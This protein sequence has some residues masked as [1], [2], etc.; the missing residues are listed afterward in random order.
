MGFLTPAFL[1]GLAALGVPI[2][3][4]MTHRPRSETVAFPS[5]MFLQRIPY[6]SSRR[7]SLRHWLL[8]ALRAAAFVLLAFAFARPFFGTDRPAAAAATG[9]TTRIVLLDRSGS[10]GYADR[11]PKAVEAARRA[12]GEL[13]PEDRASLV[14]FDA[15]PASTGEPTADRARLSS[16]LG[17]ARAG[18]GGTRYAPALR[19]AAEMLE[20]ST[21]PRREVVL[22][23][24]FQKTGW[25]GTTDARLPADT[26]LQWVDV[27]GGGASNL[28]LTGVE[29]K[30]DYDAGRER[31]IASARIVNKSARPEKDLAL[32]LEVDGRPVRQARTSLGPNT[33]AMVAFEAFPLPDAAA[34]AVIRVAPRGLPADD[35]FHFVL[36]PG[37]DVPVLVL[38]GAGASDRRSLYLRRALAI[39][40][41]PR[42]RLDVKPAARVG[43]GD[44]AGA[45]LIVSNDAPPPPGAGGQ[46]LR[47]AVEK[48]A[49]LLIVAGDESAAR[50]WT[51]GAPSL[52][53][54][55][56]GR[57]TDRSWDRGG[58]LAYLDYDHPV[59][60][61]FRGPRGGDFSAARFVRYHSLDAKEGV[62]ARYDDGAIALAERKLGRGRVLVWTSSLDT[63]GNDLALQ[64]VF[65][66]FLHQLVKY[67][68]RHVDVRP[69]YTVGEVLDLSAEAELAGK[70]A[71]VTGPGGE[72]ERLPAGRPALEL[73]EPGFYEVRR[74]EGGSW[75]RLLAVNLDPAESDLFP[76]DPEELAGAVRPAEGVRAVRR[77]EPAPTREEHEDRQAFWR[78]LLLLALGLLAVETV[79]SNRPTAPRRSALGARP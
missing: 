12:L 28:A 57:A 52:L 49:G 21:S 20:G 72:T 79:L 32:V 73:T 27:S 39:G 58:T 63:S 29:L 56:F 44:F 6:R 78:T 1:A 71:A 5:L 59:F 38:E 9:A 35:A 37:G 26:V 15:A 62:L 74:P 14:L 48:G 75:S 76:I 19:M 31:V 70:P 40:Q 46:R 47:E 30:R 51:A 18:F 24:D 11:W 43:P 67:A 4:H 42:F 50:G 13:G 41:R 8:F 55:A 16:A 7:Q 33:S 64:P 45:A 68:G 65:L 2:L 60:E 69:S 54:G 17:S 23:T 34:R 77:G 25:D 53:P 3:I 61:L 66:P 22:V 36:A 10:M